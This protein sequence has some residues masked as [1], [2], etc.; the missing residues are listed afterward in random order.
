MEHPKKQLRNESQNLLSIALISLTL[1]IIAVLAS[2]NSYTIIDTHEHIASADKA[3]ELLEANLKAGIDKTVLLATPTETLTLNGRSSFT[4]YRENFDELVKIRNKHPEQF[5]TFCTI[6]PLDP[7]VMEILDECLKKGGQGL[8]LYNG[9]SYYYDI[10]D[11]ALNSKRMK[12][13]YAFCERN[14]IPLL[15]HVNVSKY[16]SELRKVLDAHPDL[17]VSVPHFMVSSVNLNRV[18]RLLHDYPNLY[19]DVSFGSPQFMAAGLRR[20]SNNALKFKEFVHYQQSRI[21]FGADLVITEN[22]EKDVAFITDSLQCYKDMLSKRNYECPAVSAYY[23]SEMDKQ[24]GIYE[25]CAPK[26]GSYC[27]RIR[28]RRDKF[29]EYYRETEKLRG[30]NLSPFIL[31]SI[32]HKNPKAWLNQEST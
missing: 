26:E 22:E 16:E 21:L 3:D 8:K 20:I 29:T 10:F 30:L 32:Y 12:P 28:K 24:A 18:D 7:D 6:N 17:R 5:I 9:H 27:E 13:V 11:I 1:F 2:G 23:K 15:F 25:N 31:K 14:N 19:T 4:G